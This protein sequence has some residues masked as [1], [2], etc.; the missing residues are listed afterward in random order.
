MPLQ[1]SPP[2]NMFNHDMFLFEKKTYL[3]DSNIYKKDHTYIQEYL[4]KDSY[5]QKWSYYSNIFIW[6]KTYC[7]FI[8]TKQKDLLTR[9][10][11]QKNLEAKS[12]REELILFLRIT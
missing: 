6:K 8:S 10:R 2:K 11:I 7:E 9:I 12:L 4:L 5:L 1:S 3:I